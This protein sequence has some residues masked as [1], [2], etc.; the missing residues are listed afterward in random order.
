MKTKLTIL[1]IISLLFL[2]GCS[3]DEIITQLENS[4]ES[5]S[6]TPISSVDEEQRLI[7]PVEEFKDRITLKPFGIY[8]T[9]ENS[10]VQPENFSGYHTGADVEFTDRDD[11]IS[12]QAIADGS[13]IVSRTASG[14]GGLT[15][16]RHEIDG[17]KIDVIYAHLDPESLPRKGDKVEAGQIIGHLGEG[18]TTETDFERKHLH[19]SFHKNNSLD[20]RGYVQNESELENWY[21]PLEFF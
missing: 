6:P 13:V 4:L 14:Y 18:N 10:P 8:I 9:P 16:I 5:V 20:I 3:S 15:I 21:D 1:T 19:L 2:A 17:Q 11:E 7:E 12:V